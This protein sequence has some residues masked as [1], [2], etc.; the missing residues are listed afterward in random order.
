MRTYIDKGLVVVLFVFPTINVLF[1]ALAFYIGI[2]S[3]LGAFCFGL[4]TLSLWPSFAKKVQECLVQIKIFENRISS[5]LFFKKRCTILFDRTVYVS[6]FKELLLPVDKYN[7][8]EYV[9][10]SNAPIPDFE[11]DT[12]FAAFD[13]S[14][15]II[16]RDTA[17]TR[18]AIASLLASDFCVLQGDEP[19]PVET[20]WQKEKEKLL[21]AKREIAPED[22]PPFTGKWDGRF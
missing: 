2:F 9:M 7:P 5:H 11:A 10:V 21:V 3:N 17:K 13:A 4:F 22:P 1:L 6:F 15:Q 19:P 20:L 12:R 16:F 14:T 18:Q 8:H